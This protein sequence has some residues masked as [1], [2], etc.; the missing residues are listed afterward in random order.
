MMPVRFS[1]M[2]L[3]ARHDSAPIKT[4]SAGLHRGKLPYQ[5]QEHR[6][7]G[8][9]QHQR[10]L[11]KRLL[12]LGVQAAEFQRD[13]GRQLQAL[14]AVLD[15]GHRGAQIGA[16]DA[17]GNVNHRTQPFA[18]Q[19]RPTRPSIAAWRPPKAGYV[20]RSEYRLASVPA[21]RGCD[22]NGPGYRTRTPNSRSPTRSCGRHRALDHRSERRADVVGRQ[23]VAFDRGLVDQHLFL[24]IAQHQPVEHIDQTRNRAEPLARS[25]A[26]W[27]RSSPGPRQRP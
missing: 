8:R 25:R 4:A 2:K 12:L 20:R 18:I 16:F 15:A 24:R 13:S 1:P 23:P 26:R 5:H 14:Q 3:P 17:A 10:Q 27:P 22:G 19:F 9:D 21:R 6:H 7:R 11:V